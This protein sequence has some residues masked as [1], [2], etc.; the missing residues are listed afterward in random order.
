MAKTKRRDPNLRAATVARVNQLLKTGLSKAAAFEKIST[1][2]GRAKDAV[3]M[4]YYRAIRQQKGGASTRAKGALQRG[5][6][7]GGA[8]QQ[9]PS[10][11]V[12]RLLKNITDAMNALI[13]HFEKTMEENQALKAQSQRLDAISSLLR[14]R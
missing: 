11:D 3:Q 5:R 1:E 7:A 9:A 8:A 13:V 6:R 10:G 4:L 2:T 14:G 12:P